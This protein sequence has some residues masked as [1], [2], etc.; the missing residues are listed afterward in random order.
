MP[1]HAGRR[2]LAGQEQP[3]PAE[4]ARTW[5][6]PAGADP[7]VPVRRQSATCIDVDVETV[8]DA[9]RVLAALCE[10]GTIDM[11]MTETFRAQR[12][13]ELTGRYGKPRMVNCM[14]PMPA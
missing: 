1:A 3:A 8:E 6:F 9:D 10:G 12:R 7:G 4:H 11:P 13:G 2:R 14:K 5:R